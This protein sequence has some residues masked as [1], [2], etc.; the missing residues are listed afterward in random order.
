MRNYTRIAAMTLATLAV[1]SIGDIRPAQAQAI[2]TFVSGHGTDTGTCALTAPCRT[3]A[4]ALTQTASGGDIAVLDAAGYGGA[5]IT[6]SVNIINDGNGEASLTAV[7][8]GQTALTINLT[9]GGAVTLR[10]LTLAG[11]NDAQYGIQFGASGTLNIQNSVIRGFNFGVD[12]IPTG[13]ASLYVTDTIATGDYT[14]FYIAPQGGSVTNAYFER[15]QALGSGADGFDFNGIGPVFATVSDS[16]AMGNAADG[17]DVQH[18]DVMITRST[19][20]GNSTGASASAAATIYLS[21]VTLS[22]TFDFVAN[23]T[24]FSYGNNSLAAPAGNNTGTLTP[25]PQQ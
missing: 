3:I 25:A 8:I 4:Y 10:G 13:K 22:N 18:G 14:G 16:E 21:G 9:N 15:T 5:T 1:M 20:T 24:I 17:F 23:G 7:G 19:A 11:E 6:Q 2:R 12:F